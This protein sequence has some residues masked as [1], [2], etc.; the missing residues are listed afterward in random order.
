M[1]TQPGQESDNRP[2]VVQRI[3]TP[4]VPTALP[5]VDLA[6]VPADW[7]GIER[8]L[9]TAWQAGF[10]LPFVRARLTEA[11]WLMPLTAAATDF[12]PQGVRSADLTGDGR[13]EWLLTLIVPGSQSHAPIIPFTRAYPGNFYVIG[14]TG[15]LYR[16]FNPAVI[17]AEFSAAPF[18]ISSADLTADGQFDLLID[19]R[20]HNAIDNFGRY[21]FLTY[22]DGQLQDATSAELRTVHQQPDIS[23][24]PT[25]NAI[26]L[27][28][29]QTDPASSEGGSWQ[30]E[31]YQWNGDTLAKISDNQ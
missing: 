30:D 8:W 19:E 27:R 20:S 16:H 1:T 10:D 14:N 5:A 31:A 15:V 11:G 24:D 2:I 23:I 4:P 13:D 3:N 9:A 21:Y 29:W 22:R 6:V 28:Y 17:S 18:V 26:T 12:A 25:T 7:E